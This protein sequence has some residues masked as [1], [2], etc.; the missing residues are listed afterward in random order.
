MRLAFDDLYNRQK[1][2]LPIPCEP[3][4]NAYPCPMFSI[5]SSKSFVNVARETKFSSGDSVELS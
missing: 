2:D 5:R 4:I 3:P 1:V